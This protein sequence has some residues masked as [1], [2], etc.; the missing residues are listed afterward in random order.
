LP[1]NATENHRA[2]LTHFALAVTPF[3]ALVAWHWSY[4]PLAVFADWSHYLLHADALRHGRHYGDIGYIYTS[5]NPFIGP[6][7]QPPGLPIALVPVLAITSG[8]RESVVYKLFML[9]FALAVLWA[10]WTYF[11]R[12]DNRWFAAAAV[13]VT[14]LWLETAFVTNVVQPDVGF[15]V[16]LWII[17][18]IADQRSAWTWPRVAGV[19]VLG[20]AALA[21]RVAALP[22]FP[23]VGAY[24]LIHRR[25][26]GLRPF[27][28]V[29]A[30]GACGRV[31]AAV[32]PGAL[33]FAK[34]L[35][36]DVPSLV[37][38]VLEAAKAYPLGVFDLFLY[39][40]PW[41]RANDVYHAAVA[42]LAVVGG[43]GW[44]VRAWDRLLAIF[45]VFYVGMLVV[46][47]MQD[48]RYLMPLAPL[49]VFL[50][51]R[52]AAIVATWI[53]ARVGRPIVAE[54]ANRIAFAVSGFVV[55]IA[56]ATQLNQP[57]PVV[58][59]EAEGVR[60]L[61]S[62]LS[63]ANRAAPARVAF[64]NPR[65]LTWETGIPAMGFFEA[66]PDATLAEFRAKRIT[67][68]VIGDLNMDPKHFRSVQAA[69][70]ARPDA[71]RRLFAEG[72]FTVYAF[73]STAAPRP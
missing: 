7:A 25:Q 3:L 44:F 54:R 23:A 14:G 5:L 41:N 68:V 2:S 69:V 19:T 21:F 58:L 53:G 16:F 51:A 24:A 59:T 6:P 12:N 57:K 49:A 55:L 18:A 60:T 17:F 32:G 63:E 73:D 48:G 46:L 33:T 28:P 56:H 67:H 40:F 1:T 43:I 8:A 27:A 64:V 15:C 61:F 31:G 45:A 13:M 71:F 66:S 22:I 70:A 52:G 4:G 26:L 10:V 34:L 9:A 39:P 20:F 37:H 11:A 38:N 62:R 47:P 72:V 29:V 30:W 50:A 42:G 65:V 36:T 35:P